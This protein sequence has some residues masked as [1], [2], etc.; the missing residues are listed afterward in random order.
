MKRKRSYY[1]TYSYTDERGVF[2]I[3]SCGVENR[4]ASIE[5][6]ID[7][8]EWAKNLKS[9]LFG[10]KGNLVILSWREME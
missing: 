5:K 4:R 2:M 3:G 6:P 1:V 8:F 10:G 9:E 7:V